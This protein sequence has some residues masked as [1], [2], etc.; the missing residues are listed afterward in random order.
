[1]IPNNL[2]TYFF[3]IVAAIVAFLIYRNRKRISTYADNEID[4][5]KDL[6]YTDD[7][8][9]MYLE[10]YR[11]TNSQELIDLMNSGVLP[12][13]EFRAIRKILAERQGMPPAPNP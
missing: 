1:M 8:I 9:E 5:I 11:G 10:K 13:E 12:D 2:I 3:I 4:N 7:V 6:N